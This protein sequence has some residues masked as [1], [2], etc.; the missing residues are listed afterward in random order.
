[1]CHLMI[2]PTLRNGDFV[3][4]RIL[5]FTGQ[6]RW[7]DIFHTCSLCAEH[8]TVLNPIGKCNIVVSICI[9]QK[10]RFIKSTVQKMNKIV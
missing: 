9:S 6:P 7:N 4:M 1:M 8:V 10:K 3:V 2:G 5:V